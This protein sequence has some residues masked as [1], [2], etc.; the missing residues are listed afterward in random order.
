MQP[1]VHSQPKASAVDPTDEP[2]AHLFIS[3]HLLGPTDNADPPTSPQLGPFPP[4]R[5]A[6][7]IHAVS[8]VLLSQFFPLP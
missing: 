5:Q 3:L 6:E 1:F 8:H 2:R 4:K 7:N